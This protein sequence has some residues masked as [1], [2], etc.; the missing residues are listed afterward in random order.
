MYRIIG[1]RG[2]G[3]TGN[4]M[5]LAKETNSAIACL[6]PQAMRRKAMAYGIAGINFIHYKDLL[7][8]GTS[9]NVMIDEMETFVKYCINRNNLIGYSLTN[10]D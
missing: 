8:H 10:E 6:N 9:T 4:L 1:R 3:K 7:E 5:L 2:S